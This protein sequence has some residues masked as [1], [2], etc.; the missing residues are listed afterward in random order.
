MQ[1]ISGCVGQQKIRCLFI[2]CTDTRE[3]SSVTFK[4]VRLSLSYSN[5]SKHKRK[6]LRLCNVRGAAMLYFVNKR[7][8]LKC[9]PV[10][11]AV[12]LDTSFPQLCYCPTVCV[13]CSENTS[14]TP[15]PPSDGRP[16]TKKNR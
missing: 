7:D 16:R 15:E 4:Q 11:V 1:K 8:F 9:K 13:I 5:D 14:Q 6:F 12:C 2:R 3:C 10:S